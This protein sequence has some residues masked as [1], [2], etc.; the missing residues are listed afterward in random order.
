M[1]PVNVTLTISTEKAGGVLEIHAAGRHMGSTLQIKS[2]G[3][4][5]LAAVEQS[6]HNRLLENA[7][8]EVVAGIIHELLGRQ[9]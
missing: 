8:Q 3:R 7:I 9:P 2:A 6:A 4:V 1:K 5:S